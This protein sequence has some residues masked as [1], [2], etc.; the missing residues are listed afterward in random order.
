MANRA[1]SGGDYSHLHL[2]SITR[3]L[4]KTIRTQI[5]CHDGPALDATAK[6]AC[7]AS[8]F[9]LH[10]RTKHM[11]GAERK[12]G[13][14][15]NTR[16]ERELE[17][18]ARAYCPSADGPERGETRNKRNYMGGKIM[19]GR[20]AQIG[21]V[22]RPGSDLTTHND[23]KDCA[24]LFSGMSRLRRWL[25]APVCRRATASFIRL[26]CYAYIVVPYDMNRVIVVKIKIKIKIKKRRHSDKGVR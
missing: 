22:V 8:L 16:R 13:E 23:H 15:Q 12:P 19:V 1:G 20:R 5:C 26:C 21:R 18:T 9:E 14:A 6:R 24:Y 3:T 10:A 11:P 7:E 2:C 4:V 17:K 25:V